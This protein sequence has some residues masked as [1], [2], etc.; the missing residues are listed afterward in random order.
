MDIND[1]KLEKAKALGATH[2]VNGAKE[3]VPE[4]IKVSITSLVL[5]N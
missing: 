5:Q 4:K 3:N 2:T 1:K